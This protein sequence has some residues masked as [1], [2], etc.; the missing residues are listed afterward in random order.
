MV[1]LENENDVDENKKKLFFLS[2]LEIGTLPPTFIAS[3]LSPRIIIDRFKGKDG[4]RKRG[5]IMKILTHT[6]EKVTMP[7]G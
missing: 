6:L 5:G 3:K 1:I 4:N 7:I 2:F